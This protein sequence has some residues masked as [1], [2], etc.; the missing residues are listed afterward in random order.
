[1]EEIVRA[2]DE[3]AVKHSCELLCEPGRALV[4]EAE[5][6]IVRVDARRGNALY[7]NDGA[8]G[9]LFDA[10]YSG[11]R[12]PARLITTSGRETEP[13]TEFGLYG[14]TCDSS[15]YLPGPFLLPECVREG[16][17]V[18]IGQIGAYGRVLA[19]R[20]NGFGEYD[21]VV[22]TDEPML[23]MYAGQ[24]ERP[25]VTLKTARA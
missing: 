4:A 12:F 3:L 23:S 14:P 5:S 10:A 24:E 17:Y 8:F 2:A 1:M 19:N 16:D 25:L 9:T 15:D 20:F 18:E 21:E 11:F 6:V 22:L 13:E 7:V